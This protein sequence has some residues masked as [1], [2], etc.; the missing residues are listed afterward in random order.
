MTNSDAGGCDRFETKDELLDWI[1]DY[2]DYA[3]SS[4]RDSTAKYPDG[5]GLQKAQKMRGIQN[6]L[7]SGEISFKEALER[8]DR[9]LVTDND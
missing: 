3:I 5:S 1:D 9:E 4:Y 7:K 8:Y 6:D 2:C